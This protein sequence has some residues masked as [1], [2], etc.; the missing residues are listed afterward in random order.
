MSDGRSDI[1]SLGIVLY[2]LLTG[3][4]PFGGV[5]ATDTLIA[6]MQH[7]PPP[8]TQLRPETSSGLAR[9]V[10]MCLEKD[11]TR[12]YASADALSADL[13]ALDRS[14]TVGVRG[15]SIA[16]LPFSNLSPDP[17]NEYFA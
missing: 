1:F 10:A 12:R 15:P 6:T 16:V 4:P 13:E 8:I 3:H 11:P 5:T 7:D 17:Q 9:I 2:E 14:P